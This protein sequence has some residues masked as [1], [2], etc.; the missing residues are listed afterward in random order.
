MISP[1]SCS[2]LNKASTKIP[3]KYSDYIDV[4]SP[5]LA[6]KLPENTDMNEHAVELID[7]KQLP[8]GLIYALSPVDLETLK[9]YI[10]TH[11]KT[12]FI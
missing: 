7:G 6:M 11:L 10:E 5:D 9:I 4:F 8:Y 3:D 2:A 1:N 12:E